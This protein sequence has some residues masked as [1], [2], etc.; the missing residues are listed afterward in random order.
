MSDEDHI[1]YQPVAFGISIVWCAKDKY[2]VSEAIKTLQLVTL[3][4]TMLANIRIQR[5]IIKYCSS[6]IMQ[7]HN[8]K[9]LKQCITLHQYTITCL[10]LYNS[11][12][13]IF[14][15]ECS[16]FFILAFILF[17]WIRCIGYRIIVYNILA[18]VIGIF[19]GSVCST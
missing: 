6:F 11:L 5:C 1:S 7:P 8:C 19:N 13:T 17:S 14:C 2:L 18:I 9:Y 16:R 10:S 4:N 12:C 3:M 15:R